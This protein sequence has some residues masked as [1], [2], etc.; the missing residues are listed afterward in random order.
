MKENRKKKVIFFLIKHGY[1]FCTQET[2]RKLPETSIQKENQQQVGRMSS[3]KPET[4]IDL[5][6]KN[7][8]YQV[9]S[10]KDVIHCLLPSKV[11][12]FF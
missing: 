9:V 2:H 12:I 8:K 3:N 10:E 7:P 4:K 5:C 1:I 11:K 6:L